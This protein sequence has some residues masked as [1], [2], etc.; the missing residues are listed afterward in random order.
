MRIA[1]FD[2]G[3]G[4]LHSLGKALERGGAAVTV[5]RDWDQALSLDALVLPGVGAFSAAVEALPADRARVRDALAGGLPCLG[6][7]LGM[8]LLFDGSEEGA[9]EGIG[10]IPGRVRR[11]RAK[12]VPQMGWNEVEVG[13][14]PL[15]AGV[16][17]EAGTRAGDGFAE[18]PLTA[19][20]AN[21]FVCEPAD[22]T[23]AIGWSVHDG[24]RFA[25][26]V[27]R[28]RT[29]GCQFHPEK[30]SEQGR[31]IIGNFLGLVAETLGPGSARRPGSTAAPADSGHGPT[32]TA[33]PPGATEADPRTPGGTP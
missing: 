28:G 6:I 7:C 19:Y 14:D 29:W 8:Q 32:R 18:R 25:S 1:L 17:D 20:F 22:T 33:A 15:F 10:I 4:N 23:H 11:L 5:T 21:S 16:G 30:S 27:R 24:D 3:V 31:R 9:G 26:A 13:E 12:I 2:Y